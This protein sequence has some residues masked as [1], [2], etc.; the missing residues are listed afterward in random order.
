MAD[1]KD[2]NWVF[3]KGRRAIAGKFVLQP[4][5][6]NARP[7]QPVR[8]RRP[9]LTANCL[10]ME[11]E[12]ERDRETERETERQRD[13]ET[14]RERQR[15]TDLTFMSFNYKSIKHFTRQI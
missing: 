14:E 12:R 13:R 7:R 6:A 1:I 15:E 5:S 3:A 4:P 8:E 11:R 2:P 9:N 10:R